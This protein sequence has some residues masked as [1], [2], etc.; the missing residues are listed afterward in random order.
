MKHLIKTLFFGYLPL[1]LKRLFRV[2]T[3]GWWIWFFSNNFDWYFTPPYHSRVVTELFILIFSPF[4][5]S[6][7]ISG[8]INQEKN[9]NEKN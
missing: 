6:Y 2:A 9:S 4:I 8:F 5:L 3:F 1:G 7:L